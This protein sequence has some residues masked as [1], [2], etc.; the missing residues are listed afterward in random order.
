MLE[1]HLWH[2]PTKREIT[3]RV[4]IP[5]QHKVSVTSVCETERGFV[6]YT[7]TEEWKGFREV[8]ESVKGCLR[9]ASVG[10]MPNAII[11]VVCHNPGNKKNKR[12]ALF[13]RIDDGLFGDPIFFDACP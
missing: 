13:H 12:V 8:C 6:Q 7:K 5:A 9:M 4:E 10:V 11:V 2:E 3:K 1:I